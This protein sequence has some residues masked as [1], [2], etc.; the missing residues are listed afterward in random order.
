MFRILGLLN[1]QVQCTGS[2][3]F[4]TINFQ[5]RVLIVDAINAMQNKTY[6]DLLNIKQSI[7]K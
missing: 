7:L 2:T 5:K 1:I 6:D 3:T 4:S